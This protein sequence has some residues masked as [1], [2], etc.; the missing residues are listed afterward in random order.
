VTERLRVVLLGTVA[1]KM[2]FALHWSWHKKVV[3]GAT[4]IH[5]LFIIG[6]VGAWVR[7][8]NETE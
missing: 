7:G 5:P 8:T 6:I 2:M 1:V 3:S 4:G